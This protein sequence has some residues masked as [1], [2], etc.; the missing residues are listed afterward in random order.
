[1][2]Y[3]VSHVS[4]T[5]KNTPQNLQARK[6]KPRKTKALEQKSGGH[7]I[8]TAAQKRIVLD[9]RSSNAVEFSTASVIL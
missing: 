1:M 6:Q 8:L 4:Q 9:L 7:G 5:N 2:S 3:G